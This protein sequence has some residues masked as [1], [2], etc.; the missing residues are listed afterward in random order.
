MKKISTLVLL[1]IL[2]V[3]AIGCGHKKQLLTNPTVT[4]SQNSSI[5]E[6]GKVVRN[7]LKKRG[8]TVAEEGSDFVIAKLQKGALFAQ[9]KITYNAQSAQITHQSSSNLRYR[10]ING[11]QYIH[12]HY[13]LWVTNLARDIKE[14]LTKTQ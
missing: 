7:A 12:A 14:Q 2:S 11:N 8:W 6:T 1:G 5:E 9:I 4:L 13:N 10:E 3:T